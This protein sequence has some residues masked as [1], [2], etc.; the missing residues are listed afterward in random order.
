MGIASVLGKYEDQLMRMPNVNGVGIGENG[1]EEVIKVYVTRKLPESALQAH[2]VIP[3][4]LE[5]FSTDV[6]ESQD[7]MAQEKQ[8]VSGGNEK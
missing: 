4:R 6:E 8:E 2:E 7:A 3:K 5:G 1:G